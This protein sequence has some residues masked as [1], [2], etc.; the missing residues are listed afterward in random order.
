M[1]YVK[2]IE[3]MKNTKPVEDIVKELINENPKIID[4]EGVTKNSTRVIDVLSMFISETNSRIKLPNLDEETYAKV[5]NRIDAIRKVRSS[6][7][8][9][10]T[11]KEGDIVRVFTDGDYFYGEFKKAYP[12]FLLFEKILIR[13][14]NMGNT[15]R[16]TVHRHDLRI[17]Q[18]SLEALSNEDKEFLKQN[19]I[20]N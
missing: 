4:C 11:L 15:Y 18:A 7:S 1:E 19:N 14:S 16:V 5:L 9:L 8:F 12:S 6:Q 2:L 20:L 13:P 17:G 3:I 10:E